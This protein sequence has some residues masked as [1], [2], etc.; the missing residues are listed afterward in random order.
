MQS[1]D[2]YNSEAI[3]RD[4]QIFI[5]SRFGKHYMQRLEQMQEQALRLAMDLN[6]TADYRANQVTRAAA[7]K[8]EIDYF[9]LAKQVVGSPSMLQRIRE[10]VKARTQK[11]E[12]KKR[13]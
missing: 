3:A 7:I 1:P 4:A 11:K 10:N 8:D 9:N 12:V 13:T 2:E 6:Y 5:D